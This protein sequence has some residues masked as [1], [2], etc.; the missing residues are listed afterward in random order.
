MASSTINKSSDGKLIAAE[1]WRVNKLNK[2]I[3]QRTILII[4]L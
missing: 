3:L 1:A 4:F 2:S